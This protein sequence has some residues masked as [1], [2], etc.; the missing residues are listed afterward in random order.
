MTPLRFRLGIVGAGKMG[1]ALVRAL[2]ARNA[3]AAGDIIAADAYPQAREALAESCPG[4]TVTDAVAATVRDSAVLMVAVKPQ[5]FEAALADALPDRPDGQLVVSVMAGVPLSRMSDLLGAEAA[6]IR[7]MPNILCEVA[8]GAFGYAANAH[9]SAEQKAT[10]AGWLNALGVA[11]ELDERLLDAVT[12]L[13]GSGPAFVAVFIEALADGGVAAG[14]PRA[15]AQRLAA[16]TVLGTA[17][18]VQECGHPAA[19]KDM[20]ASPAGTTITGLRELETRGLRSAASEAVVA[21]A[22]RSSELGQ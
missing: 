10:V 17:R 2:V 6:I 13:S 21:A 7:V 15:T 1:G 22:R 20:V 3:L 12:G 14:L 8:E 19:L 4:V 5:D 11:D 18:W 16:Q 9:V